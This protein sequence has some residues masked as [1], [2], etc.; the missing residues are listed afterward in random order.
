MLIDFRA[1]SSPYFTGSWSDRGAFKFVAN[2]VHH[3]VSQRHNQPTMEPSVSG[4]K[5]VWRGS[6]ALPVGH[7]FVLTR[8]SRSRAMHLLWLG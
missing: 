8:T 3:F 7:F 2:N 5:F 1:L 6:R 4:F